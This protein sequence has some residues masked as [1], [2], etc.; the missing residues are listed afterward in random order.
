M[1]KR[2]RLVTA[3]RRATKERARLRR[4]A[5]RVDTQPRLLSA[6]ERLRERLPGDE[7]FGDALSTT[8]TQP[9]EVLGRGVSALQPNRRSVAAELGFAG[10]QVW[11]SLSGGG[12]PRAR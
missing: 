2:P 3:S 7:R 6:T 9:V 11:Q 5:V 1:V 4:L 10:L 12:R 8:G